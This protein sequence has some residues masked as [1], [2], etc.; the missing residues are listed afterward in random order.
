MQD[1]YFHRKRKQRD[2]NQNTITH[3]SS[4]A[5]GHARHENN[6]F[7]GFSFT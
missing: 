5:K 2:F 4:L 1:N 3:Q 6:T 7:K